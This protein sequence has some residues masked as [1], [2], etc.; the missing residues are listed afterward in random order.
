MYK[1]LLWL[2]LFAI[3]IPTFGQ[4][5]F[6]DNLSINAT[7]HI[8]FVLPEYQFINYVTNDFT[9]SLDFSI[10]KET[11][12][13]NEWEQRY[14]YPSYGLSFFYSTLGNDNVL[15]R[16]IAISP[17]FRI[18][19]FRKKNFSIYNQTGLGI[20]YISKKF[21]L[22]ENFINVAVGSNLNIHFNLRM[23][24]KYDIG[25]KFQLMGGASFDHFSNANTSE[26]NLGI[27]YLSYYLGLGYRLSDRIEKNTI[28]LQPNE[29]EITNELVY[30]IGGKH[31]RALSSKYYFTS[32]LSFEKRKSFFKALHLGVGADLFFDTS[33][34][35]Q[36]NEKDER[37]RGIYQFQTGIHMS[38][39][40]IYE[41]FSITLQEGVYI[42]LIERIE[43]YVMY[44]RGIFK[45]WINERFSV[46]LTMKSHLHILDYPEIGL[47][48][49]L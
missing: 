30:S 45:Y 48:I 44:N 24:M 10:V 49:K 4:D 27:N 25:N 26:P 42:G 29:K 35:D 28:E 19:L 47:G 32:S 39:S 34:E 3:I 18:H 9:K 31:S 20:G 21:D 37:Y 41:R 36:L 16:E 6:K 1:L 12:G 33:I 5:K 46:R 23:G 11:T 14:N 15:G 2:I 17:F 13:K 8:G 40:I 43:D 22:E 7:S 38:Q